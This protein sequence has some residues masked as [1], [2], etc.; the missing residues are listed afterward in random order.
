MAILKHPDRV[1]AVLLGE[2]KKFDGAYPE[3][4]EYDLVSDPQEVAADIARNVS[5][6][7]TT[8]ELHR[9][10]DPGA[11]SC[12]TR[13]GV[14][15]SYH[16]GT[17]KAD[18]YFCFTCMDLAVYLNDKPVGLMQFIFVCKRL[19]DDMQSIFPDHTEFADLAKRC[20]SRSN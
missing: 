17:D 18:L 5:D 11:K 16:S 6:A 12:I 15:M 2:P 20:H 4:H 19:L 8:R 3:P 1:E 10:I 7:L 13:Y 14:R 9:I